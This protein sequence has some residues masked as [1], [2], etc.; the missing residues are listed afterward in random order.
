MFLSAG[1]LFG[2]NTEGF[3][4]FC[5]ELFFLALRARL[6][7]ASAAPG[8][9]WGVASK[10]ARWQD[11]WEPGQ[12]WRWD[13]LN[14]AFW[15]NCLIFASEILCSVKRCCYLMPWGASREDAAGGGPLGMVRGWGC[16]PASLWGLFGWQCCLLG[17]MTL[18]VKSFH[19]QLFVKI[20]E[21]SAS[22]ADSPPSFS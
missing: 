7:W 11:A 17:W 5:L 13:V 6:R 12:W 4:A 18:A 20:S 10:G 14:K 9:E 22:K 15:A 19:F 3:G 1:I 8:R 21:T 16:I 2:E